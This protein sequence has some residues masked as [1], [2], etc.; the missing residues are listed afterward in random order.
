MSGGPGSRRPGLRPFSAIGLRQG[1]PGIPGTCRVGGGGV[2]A[3]GQ[4]H[5]L[6]LAGRFPEAPP[7]PKR[8]KYSD[9]SS[10]CCSAQTGDQRG[11]SHLPPFAGSLPGQALSQGG[12]EA[13]LCPKDC[14]LAI[15]FPFLL[16]IE[17]WCVCVCLSTSPRETV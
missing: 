11:R 2:S 3:R 5:S 1:L 10:V 6:P 16:Q 15:C 4:P 12:A 7:I 14:P 8:L 17:T 9:S 13:Q